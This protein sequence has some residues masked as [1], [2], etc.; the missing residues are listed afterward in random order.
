M[1]AFLCLIVFVLAYWI[2]ST[3]LQSRNDRG[4]VLTNYVENAKKIEKKNLNQMMLSPFHSLSHKYLTEEKKENIQKK[5]DAAGLETKPEEYLKMKVAYPII[6]TSIFLICSVFHDYYLFKVG[7]IIAPF[8]YFYPDYL[9]K[10]RMKQ[11]KEERRFELPEFLIPL[12]QI[13]K[14]HT[15]LEAVKKTQLYAG[16]YIRPYVNTL[17]AELEMYAGS[18]Q[19]FKNFAN[20]LDIPEV[21]TFTI[22]LQQAQKTDKVQSIRI[23]DSQIKMMRELKHENYNHLIQN[24]PMQ[25]NKYNVVVIG[26]IVVYPMVIVV[27]SLIQGFASI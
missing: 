23:M 10:M 7:I 12:S 17:A 14:T 2:F 8:L 11:A 19:P 22:A 25:M 15:T 26:C 27:Q 5:L 20:A 13:L 4:S 6:F 18:D 3:F 21:N 16:S 9:L 24:K 1:A